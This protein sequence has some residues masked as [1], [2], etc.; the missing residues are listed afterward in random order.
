MEAGTDLDE[1]REPAVNFDS[2]A[3]RI[4]DSA[5]QLEQFPLAGS[6][7]PDDAK[8]LPRVGSQR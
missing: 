1:G 5:D 7:G 8:A 2:A 3:G 6:V 4:R